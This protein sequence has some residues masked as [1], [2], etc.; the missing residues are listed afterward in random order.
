MSSL[1][2]CKTEILFR[3]NSY[4]SFDTVDAHNIIFSL[5]N[6]RWCH[7]KSSDCLSVCPSVR[8]SVCDNEAQY[9]T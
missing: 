9:V 8:P 6:A 5:F 2:Q 7:R 4:E 1:K 3:Y